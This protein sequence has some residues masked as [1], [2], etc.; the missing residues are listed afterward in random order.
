M[1]LKMQ[2]VAPFLLL[3]AGNILP[4]LAITRLWAGKAV[5]WNSRPAKR[6]SAGSAA[7]TRVKSA[8]S[9]QP[10]EHL[11]KENFQQCRAIHPSPSKATNSSAHQKRYRSER[12][13]V[14]SLL[15]IRQFRRVD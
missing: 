7:A 3:S 5:R 15:R 11:L 12:W 13:P 9:C 14:A 1:I 6:K 8:V 2:H 4:T 10:A